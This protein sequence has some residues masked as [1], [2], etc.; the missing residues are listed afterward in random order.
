MSD[1]TDEHL[2]IAHIAGDKKAFSEL[3]RRY[4]PILSG[5]ARRQVRLPELARDIVQQTFLQVHRARNDF[6][7]G[8]QLKPWVLTIATN[9]IREHF[10][11]TKR[12]PETSYEA[13]NA[14]YPSVEPM[15][16]PVDFAGIQSRALEVQRLNDA[17][18]KLPES[19]RLVIELHW[20]Q[21][22]PFAEVAQM[23]GASVSAVKVRAHRGYR[24][25]RTLIDEERAG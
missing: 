19:Q 17:L 24:K 23:V 5:M 16:E 20:I 8:A 10:R 14:E 4:G 11:R 3:V 2:M 1:L 6:R 22:Y 25:L 9:L 13:L 21:G 7:V 12:R 15:V 18:V